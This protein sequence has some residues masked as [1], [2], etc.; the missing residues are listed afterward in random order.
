M[1]IITIDPSL[2]CTAVVV[3]DKKYCFVKKDV[4]VTSKGSHKKWFEL[5]KDLVTI[6]P[7]EY[8]M[9][10]Q[11][12]HQE[13]MKLCDYDSITS[14]IV[15][16][17]PTTITGAKVIIEGYSYSSISGPLIDLVTFSTLLRY[18]IKNITND[19]TILP[20]KSLKSM[21]ASFTYQ[22]KKVG[23]K[24]EYRNHEGISGGQFK[25]PEMYKCLI[26]NPTLTC[27]WVEF[28]RSHQDEILKSK[29]VPK[30]IEDI[31][32]AKLMYEI[33]KNNK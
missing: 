30:P 13:I 16:L 8:G 32:D 18:K 25:K 5:C 19:I 33:F 9:N 12:S 10:S 4:M 1:D 31:N 26:N 14:Q 7:V 17:I 24:T 28:L 11:F 20:P 29:S 21:A 6:I 23:K 22:P 2:T 3:N 15:N 27:N